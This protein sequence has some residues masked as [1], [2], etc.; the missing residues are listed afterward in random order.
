ME[1][2]LY[3]LLFELRELNRQ[4][5]LAHLQEMEAARQADQATRVSVVTRRRVKQVLA[6]KPSRAG[7]NLSAHR[8]QT[9]AWVHRL[10]K[11]W[12]GKCLSTA[13]DSYRVPLEFECA[14]RHRFFMRILGLRLGRWCRRCAYR[15]SSKYTLAGAHAVADKHGGC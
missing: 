1:K 7:A 4:I 12:G 3:E 5:R 6:A 11:A 10:A 14:A 15:R 2:S 8:A 9:Q 13:Y